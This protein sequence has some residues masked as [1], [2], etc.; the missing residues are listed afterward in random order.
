MIAM[1]SPS[2]DAQI[3]LTSGVKAGMNVATL[4]Y[5]S[6]G[7]S[8]GSANLISFHGGLFA[9]AKLSEK[10]AIHIDFLYSSQ[11]GSSLRSGDFTLGYF[12][13]PVMFAYSFVP[14]GVVEVGLQ[15]SYL[16]SASIRGNEA[17]DVFN[18]FDCG[19]VFGI[20]VQGPSGINFGLRYISGLTE[21]SKPWAS[22]YVGLYGPA[23]FKMV[24]K[25]L[26]VS[27]G[28]TLSR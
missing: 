5:S 10:D 21:M 20:G 17:K 13:I 19:L 18:E 27:V 3:Q 12:S 24:N 14:G 16:L 7:S 15:P 25:V 2:L 9:K 4:S 1:T 26:Q 22:Y 11:G 8:G 23:D 28:Y 6:G